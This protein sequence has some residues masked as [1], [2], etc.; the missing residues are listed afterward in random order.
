MRWR[1]DTNSGSIVGTENARFDIDV[2]GNASGFA[3]PCVPLGDPGHGNC[4]APYIACQ[5]SCCP[6]DNPANPTACPKSEPLIDLQVN[7]TVSGST[8]STFTEQDGSYL[9]DNLPLSATTPVYLQ[10]E[11]VG[12]WF[13]VRNYDP[14]GAILSAATSAP[15]HSGAHLIFNTTPGDCDPWPEEFYTAQV[16]AYVAAQ[17][18]RDWFV[19]YQGPGT[20][21][22]RHVMLKVNADVNAYGDVACGG[23]MFLGVEQPYMHLTASIPDICANTAYSTIVSHE[24]GHFINHYAGR[25]NRSA[26]EMLAD[27]TAAFTW[28]TPHIAKDWSFDGLAAREIDVPD[29]RL[30]ECASFGANCTAL[31]GAFWDLRQAIIARYA[32]QG[33]EFGIDVAN[34]MLTSFLR[35][36]NGRLGQHNLVE[37]LAVDDDDMSFSSN[38]PTPHYQEIIQAFIGVHGWADAHCEEPVTVKWVGP[39][40]EPI[41]GPNADYDV[42]YSVCPPDVKLMTT[43]VTELEVTRPVT[44]WSVGRVD[45]LTDEPLDLGTVSAAWNLGPT[46][47]QH[48]EEVLIGSLGIEAVPCRSVQAVNIPAQHATKYTN[49]R[50]ELTGDLVGSAKCYAATQGPEAGL[51]G[52]ISGTIAGNVGALTARAIGVGAAQPGALIVNGEMTGTFYDIPSGSSLDAKGIGQILVNHSLAGNMRIR[53]TSALVYVDGSAPGHISFDSDFTGGQIY[54][55]NGA[56]GSIVSEGDLLGTIRVFGVFDGDICA[57]NLQNLQPG[58]QLPPN[59]QIDQFGPNATICDVPVCGNALQA[60]SADS[61]NRALSFSVPPSSPAAQIETAIRVT[62]VDLYHPVPAN[63]P[64]RPQA[65]LLDLRYDHEQRVHRPRIAYRLLLPD[66]R[67][68]PGQRDV[69]DGRR[70]H[71]AVRNRAPAARRLRPLCRPALHLR[72]TPR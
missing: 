56:T 32:A 58:E 70:L 52:R 55:Y 66:E 41:E 15:P 62:L 4:C 40:R 61:K 17:K 48:V 29:R 21:I 6:S 13:T 60:A 1:H 30:W 34:T 37:A 50:L 24:F 39:L 16:N 8:Y 54:F 22:D 57:D 65:E 33:Q 25:G 43:E 44:Q 18:T 42:D 11:L 27:L 69:S 53:G 9:F 23:H 35:L 64:S 3:T 31:Q 5:G 72:R 26:A 38:P 28:D 20:G 71:R 47:P 68:L 45:P 19:R 36:T 10:A 2:T 46:G 59:I 67:R 7:A 63:P 14:T 51:G 49:L 12:R